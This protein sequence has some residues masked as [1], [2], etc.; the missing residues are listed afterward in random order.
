MSTAS[1]SIANMSREA[2]SERKGILLKISS[3]T[4]KQPHAS[5]LP[6]NNFSRYIAKWHIYEAAKRGVIKHK[7]NRSLTSPTDCSSEITIF[8]HWG[9]HVNGPYHTKLIIRKNT[10]YQSTLKSLW[11]N[12]KYIS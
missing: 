12:L 3:R 1:K 8:R 7:L 11:Y 9:S 2:I 5:E 6:C 10:L 4:I